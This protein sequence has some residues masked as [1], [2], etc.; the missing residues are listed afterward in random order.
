[1]FK[2]AQNE[3][4]FWPIKVDVPQDGGTFI[5]QKFEAKFKRL[6]QTR[7]KEISKQLDEGII[8]EVDV[9]REVMVDWKGVGND[10]GPLEFCESNFSLL[11]ENVYAVRGIYLGFFESVAGSKVK[12]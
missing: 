3:T 12:N 7:L 4:Y 8:N 9:C 11:L 5:Q 10:S 2:L 1:M 6:S